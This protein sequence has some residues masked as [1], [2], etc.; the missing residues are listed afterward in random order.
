MRKKIILV[1]ILPAAFLFAAAPAFA[2]EKID[3]SLDVPRIVFHGTKRD[4]KLYPKG[5]F[6]RL[7]LELSRPAK[8]YLLEIIDLKSESRV[9]ARSLLPLES[10]RRCDL[11]QGKLFETSFKDQLGYDEL[12]FRYRPGVRAFI[13]SSRMEDKKRPAITID[14]FLSDEAGSSGN[15]D[16]NPQ[17]AKAS[18][19]AAAVSLQPLALALPASP[20]PPASATA[21]G[22]PPAAASAEAVLKETPLPQFGGW[23]VVYRAPNEHEADRLEKAFVH[24]YGLKHQRRYIRIFRRSLSKPLDGLYVVDL[25]PHDQFEP[26]RQA[27]LNR[28]Q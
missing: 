8:S 9:S 23:R 28:S 15:G 2:E 12:S 16:K 25:V 4:D 13:D 21:A 3:P 6:E 11:P 17:D 5:I 19:K 24:S 18:M 27:E 22:P 7:T 14:F 20:Q 26:Y 10:P 1:P